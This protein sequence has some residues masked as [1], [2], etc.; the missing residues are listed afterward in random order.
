MS[1]FELD[2]LRGNPYAALEW[3]DKFESNE[4]ANTVSRKKINF[5]GLAEQAESMALGYNTINPLPY[6]TAVL[7]MEFSLRIYKR[8]I[9][10][11]DNN[12]ILN[13]WIDEKI[14]FWIPGSFGC[15]YLSEEPSVS[16]ALYSSIAWFKKNL[17]IDYSAAEQQASSWYENPAGRTYVFKSLLKRLEFIVSLQRSGKLIPDRELIPWIHLWKN[18]YN[19]SC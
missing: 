3:L 14:N 4:D 1:D 12:E 19:R 13:G 18:I 9:A 2:I 10:V 11:N 16:D 6:P 8:L 17:A 5:I 15:L 7:W